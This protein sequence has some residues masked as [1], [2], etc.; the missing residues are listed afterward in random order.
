VAECYHPTT[1]LLVGGST[2]TQRCP[3]F[4]EL[5]VLHH[6]LLHHEINLF[7]F[8]TTWGGGYSTNI[9]PTLWS[10]PNPNKVAFFFW[11]VFLD[12]LPTKDNLRRNIVF[13]PLEQLFPL[14]LHHPESLQHLLLTCDIARFAC[15]KC[16]S[17]WSPSYAT[18]L[19]QI[20]NNIF[21]NSWVWLDLEWRD[22]C[23][24]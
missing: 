7:P 18:M 2:P 22:A 12:D 17:W 9:F 14:C 20:Y 15:L 1:I 6:G 24:R 23:G 19:H 21:G 16:Y 13:Q 5:E 3:R 10:I 8:D 11:I 4:L